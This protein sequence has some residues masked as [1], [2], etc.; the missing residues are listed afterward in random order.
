MI[1]IKDILKF[2][3]TNQL[4]K[5]YRLNSVD[6][7]HESS[8]EHSWSSMLL[9][10]WL[11][12]EIDLKVN[13]ERVKRL[14]LYH[15]IVEIESGDT[16]L[17]PNMK[18]FEKEQYQKE[19]ECAK[20]LRQKFPKDFG[21]KFYEYFN[22]F[23]TLRTREAKVAKVIDVLDAEIHEID[24]KKDFKGWTRKFIE[25]SKLKYFEEFPEM[26]K[27]FNEIMDYYQNNGYFD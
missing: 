15:D 4:K 12:D 22:E 14:L 10:D 17:H 21:N 5:V 1:E 16:A 18:I 26:K 13:K 2:K 6:N 3:K 20:V 8:A 9:A 11:L 27:I 7:R 25:D 24:Q 23:I 19:H